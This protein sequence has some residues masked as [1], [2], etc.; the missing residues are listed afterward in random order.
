MKL[1]LGLAAALAG[2]AAAAQQAAEVYIISNG[3]PES[4][5]TPSISPSLARLILL[6][7]LAPAG[8]G[9][10]T[11]DIPDGADAES[12]V[13]LMNQFGKE[14]LSLFGEGEPVSPR[15]LVVML[16]GLTDE[17]IKEMGKALDT[18]PAFTIADPPSSSAHDKLV[19]GDFYNAG[20]AKEH[21]CLVGEVTNPF[22]DHCWSGMSTVAKYNVQK[23]S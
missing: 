10:S 9:P 3:A 12:V 11:A 18:K 7:R 20:V 6:Q 22:A 16:E 19:K 4:T 8:K 17:Q 13:D 21:K 14:P 1:N 5:S 23:V 15:Q 2:F